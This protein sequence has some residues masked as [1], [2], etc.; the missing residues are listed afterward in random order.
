MTLPAAATTPLQYD[1]NGVR[2]FTVRRPPIEF[3]IDDDVFH[4]PNVIAPAKL[5][6]LATAAAG[7]DMNTLTSDTTGDAF[8]AAVAKLANLFGTLIGGADGRLFAAR[9]QSRGRRMGDD[10]ED[11]NGT[12]IPPADDPLPIDLTGQAIPVL[13]FLLESYGMRPTVPSSP[14]SAGS[15]D[16][17]P[18]TAGDGTSSTDGASIEA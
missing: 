16:G 1:E 17:E 9:M 3:R 4:A 5:K 15:T 2:D 6:A 14:L 12:P 13:W 18:A 7:I 11:A 8:E 10:G